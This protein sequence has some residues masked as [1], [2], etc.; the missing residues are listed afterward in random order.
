MFLALE[1]LGL[2]HV[3]VH[4]GATSCSKLVLLCISSLFREQVISVADISS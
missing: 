1:K 4:L 3:A 2:E